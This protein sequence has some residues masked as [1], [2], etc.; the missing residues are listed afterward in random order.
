MSYQDI[1]KTLREV[2]K[3]VPKEIRDKLTT[4]SKPNEHHAE[5]IKEVLKREGSNL[6]KD[7]QAIL[8]TMA[9]SPMIHKE[10]EKRNEQAEKQ[11]ERYIEGRVK[12]LV[13]RGELP[14]LREGKRQYEQFMKSRKQ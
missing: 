2:G 12:A 1:E 9:E 11:A 3:Y 4:I 6:S 10:V 5:A 13:D 8:R 14:S 7:T